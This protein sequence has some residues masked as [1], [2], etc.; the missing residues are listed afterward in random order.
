M[1]RG[2]YGDQVQVKS[3]ELCQGI[4]REPRPRI[5]QTHFRLERRGRR[6]E[7]AE[8]IRAQYQE[9]VQSRREL[10]QQPSRQ[11][12]AAAQASGEAPQV[13][14]STDLEEV[15]RQA[16]E[17]WLAMRAAESV[18]PAAGQETELGRPGQEAEE[19]LT[20]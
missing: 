4:D 19:D 1:R 2:I 9:R 15:R 8:E 18:Q 12:P 13:N 14:R 17:S 16:R 20:R 11:Q 3:G 5:P 6:S 7:I 10:A